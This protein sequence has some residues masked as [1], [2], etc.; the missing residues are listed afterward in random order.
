MWLMKRHPSLSRLLKS[1]VMISSWMW[2]LMVLL[3]LV[4]IICIYFLLRRWQSTSDFQKMKL[5]NAR[6]DEVLGGIDFIRSA[7]LDEDDNEVDEEQIH[8]S[9]RDPSNGISMQK[10]GQND[11]DIL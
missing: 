9:K 10:I 8:I 6:V 1:E 5:T 3:V 4:I 2:I 11:L 7:S